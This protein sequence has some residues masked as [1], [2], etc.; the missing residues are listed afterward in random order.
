MKMPKHTETW[1]DYATRS[2]ADQLASIERQGPRMSVAQ[3]QNMLYAQTQAELRALRTV[4]DDNADC[5]TDF[6]MQVGYRALTA[7]WERELRIA[8]ARACIADER[9][10]HATTRPDLG[11]GKVAY[12]YHR[13]PQSPTGVKLAGSLDID[14]PRQSALL[15]RGPH[16]GPTRGDLART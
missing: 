1:P 14:D 10:S 15:P 13:D 12:L 8:E 16:R 7:A 2:L 5:R 9:Y 11:S 4:V 6:W 3:I